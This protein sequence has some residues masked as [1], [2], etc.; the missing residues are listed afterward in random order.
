[1]AGGGVDAPDT[2]QERGKKGYKKPPVRSVHIDM[3]PMVD[4]MFTGVRPMPQS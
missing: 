1:M 4:I 2:G 3:T